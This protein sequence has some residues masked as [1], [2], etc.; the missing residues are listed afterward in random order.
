M[1]L[2]AVASPRWRRHSSVGREQRR[3]T[4][5]DGFENIEDV[6]G[7]LVLKEVGRAY[8]LL[9]GLDMKSV[10]KEAEETEVWKA[11]GKVNGKM[12]RTKEL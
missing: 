4:S 10:N 12:N 6:I 8:K 9:A 2:R 1:S 7:I 5:G 11:R 3:S